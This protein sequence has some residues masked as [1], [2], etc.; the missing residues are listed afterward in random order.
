MNS[1]ILS[2]Q[3]FG[4]LLQWPQETDT[5]TLCK[6]ITLWFTLTL[7]KNNLTSQGFTPNWCLA[8]FLMDHSIVSVDL[9]SLIHHQY[10]SENRYLQT[11][12]QQHF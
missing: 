1:A 2:H 9:N 11:S 4:N 12:Q 10:L 7:E 6:Y 3:V 8:E 5:G